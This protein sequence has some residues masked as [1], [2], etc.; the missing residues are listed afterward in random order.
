MQQLLKEVPLTNAFENNI[1]QVLQTSGH[2]TEDI[3]IMNHS[4]RNKRIYD[5]KEIESYSSGNERINEDEPKPRHEI[6][7]KVVAKNYHSRSVEDKGSKRNS[8]NLVEDQGKS[9]KIE[10]L[11]LDSEELENLSSDDDQA[12]ISQL[13]ALTNGKKIR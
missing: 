8:A 6:N 3:A 11:P 12:T 1:T 13:N 10:I 2:K 5:V 7:L 9:P 4:K